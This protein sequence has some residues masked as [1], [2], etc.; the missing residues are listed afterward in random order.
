MHMDVEL[1]N[2][3]LRRNDT[4]LICSDVG[5]KEMTK[6][7]PMPKRSRR[8]VKGTGS[9]WLDDRMFVIGS[10]TPV[11]VRCWVCGGFGRCEGQQCEG[12]WCGAVARNGVSGFFGS[13][14]RE[15]YLLVAP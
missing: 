9:R 12:Q 5:G 6:S 15:G 7:V 11:H 13:Q 14:G 1:N 3:R 8:G 10:L 2:E 4:H